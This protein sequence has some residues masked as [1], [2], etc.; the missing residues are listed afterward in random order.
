MLFLPPASCE[1]LVLISHE[2]HADFMLQSTFD[3][4][5]HLA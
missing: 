4:K 5:I 3:Y 1:G 2:R